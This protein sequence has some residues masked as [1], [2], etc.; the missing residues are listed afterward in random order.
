L[1]PLSLYLF[2]HLSTTS[3]LVPFS[4]WNLIL[5]L[6]VHKQSEWP[7]SKT[8][9]SQKVRYTDSDGLAAHPDNIAYEK[10]RSKDDDLTWALLDYEV[11]PQ[12]YKATQYLM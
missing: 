9:K 7:T 11:G 8:P 5:V 10:I 1:L 2:P 12:A 4:F 3:L 6:S